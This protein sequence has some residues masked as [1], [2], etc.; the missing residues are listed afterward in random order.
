MEERIRDD[1]F[2]ATFVVSIPRADAWRRLEE[3]APAVE[4]IGEAGGDQ[5][6][7][8]GVESPA[9]PLEVRPGEELRA[10]KAEE[11]CKGTEI[12]VTLE[13][14]GTGTRITIVQTGF[15]PGFSAQRPWLAS[16]WAAILADVVAYFE[17]GVSLGRHVTWWSSIGCD[18]AE[19]DEGLVVARV[20]DGGFGGEAGLE[21]GDLILQ[22]AGAPVIDVRDLSV[23]VR[24][25]LRSGTEAEVRYLRGTEVRVG[26]GTI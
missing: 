1:G 14:E 24:G 22:L 8:P 10:R 19:T 16:G 17:R 4:G 21:S 6:W 9:D 25:P 18:V 7:I 12:V 2:E 11:P 5:W 23:L 20:R 26:V 3:A 13:D 15:G